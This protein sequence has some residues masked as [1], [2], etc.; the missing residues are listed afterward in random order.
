MRSLVVLLFVPILLFGQNKKGKLDISAHYLSSKGISI[1]QPSS[2]KSYNISGRIGN[3]AFELQMN[4]PFLKSC[5]IE[6]GYRLKQHYL[7]FGKDRF[8][9]SEWIET[10]HSV[11]LRVSGVLNKKHSKPFRRLSLVGSGGILIDFMQQSSSKPLLVGSTFGFTDQSGTFSLASDYNENEVNQVKISMSLD[12]QFRVGYHLFKI[13]D[14]YLGYGYTQGTRI[15][16]KGNYSISTPTGTS[17]GSMK[18]RGSYRYLILGL[19]VHKRA[20]R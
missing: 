1:Q 9:S 18:S 19:H 10:T 6:T 16:G 11:P 15:I 7:T 5:H 20:S 3:P 14:F 12:A 2:G 17:T 4:F 13:L 8:D